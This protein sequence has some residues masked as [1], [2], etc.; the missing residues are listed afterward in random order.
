MFSVGLALFSSF[1]SQAADCG[2][3]D[4]LFNMQSQEM[5]QSHLLEVLD[6]CPVHAGALNNLALIRETSG[7]LPEAA[8]LYRRAIMAGGGAPPQAG[9]G[10]VLATQGDRDGAARAYTIFLELAAEEVANGDPNGLADHVPLYQQRLA[11]LTAQ[12]TLKSDEDRIDDIGGNGNAGSSDQLVSAAEM[13]RGLTRKP[14]GTR[15]MSV[16][17]HEE[18]HIDVPILFDHD[19]DWERAILVLIS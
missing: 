5:N 4:T 17:Y 11:A 8:S 14:L 16:I 3:A 13:T 7:D 6:L 1:P 9:L 15:G 2:R 19:S 10:D 18:P 12:D